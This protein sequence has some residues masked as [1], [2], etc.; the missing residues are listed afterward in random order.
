M[1]DFEVAVRA[2][3]HS[4]FA[5]GAGRRQRL[6]RGLRG[7]LLERTVADGRLRDGLFR[8]VDVLPQ[9]NGA[10]EVAEHLHAYLAAVPR[11]G[12][13]G[14]LF[15]LAA[16]P[17]LA[18]MVRGMVH[19]LARDFM[20][21]ES[22]HGL[23]RILAEL[24]RVPAAA[25]VDAVG[26]AVL[27]EA[28]ADAYLARNLKLLGWLAGRGRPNISIKLTGLSPRFDPLD[29]TGTRARVEA[30]LAPLLDAAV[31]TRATVTVDMEQRDL[32]GQILDLF[33]AMAADFPGDWQPA[34]AMQA[35]LPEAPDDLAR[36]VA[37][38]ERQGRRLGV[39]LVK[40]AY[41]DQEQAWAAQ[42]G[43]PVP[44]LGDKA[45]TDSQYESL[46]AWLF[47]RSE[48]L[49]PAVA[50]HNLRSQSV[51]LAHA[52]RR[53][54]PMDG[55][56]WEA[57]MLYGMAEPLRDALAAAGVPLR[58]YV[59]T[60]ELES[61]I[62]YLIRRLL[63]N[64]ASTSILQQTQVE[65]LDEA[66]LLAAPTPVAAPSP[67]TR[68]NLANVPLLDFSVEG[69]RGR[70][71]AAL[72]SLRAELPRR[73]ARDGD[74][75]F[76]ARNPARPAEELGAVDLVDAAAVDAAVHR[77]RLAFAGWSATPATERCAKLRRAADLIVE[78]RREL[79]ALEVLEVAKPWREADADVAEAADFLRY[80]AGQ[81]E[82]LAGWRATIDF[83]GEA[84]RCAYAPRGVAVVIAPWNFPLA[85][86]AGM[87]GAALAAGNCAIMKPA[88]SALLVAHELRD[89]LLAA[90]VPAD[91]A[92]LLPGD[93]GVGAALVGHADIDVIAFT[94]SRQV[95]LHILQAAYTPAPGQRHVKQVVCEMGGKNAIVVDADADLDEAV[96]GILV[97]AFGYSGQKCSACSRIIAVDAVHDRLLARLAAA[98][99]ALA[100]GPP[101]NPACDHGPLI[102]EAARDKALAYIEIGRREGRLVW[103]GRVPEDGG[104]YAPPAIFAGIEPHHRLARD[105]VF[106]PVLA[107]L[108]AGNFREALAMAGD[109]DYA[110]TGGVYSRLPP[111]LML[112]AESFRVGNLYLNRRITGAR[113]GVQPFGGIA[114]SGT[115]V[116]AGGPDYLKQFLWT[117]SVSENTMRHGMLPA[118]TNL[119]GWR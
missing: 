88:L 98:A 87:T 2:I 92:Q 78:R 114:L 38:A 110:L 36:V 85:I 84:N 67:D 30:R 11:S 111:H 50:S 76:V 48:V 63:E 105:E 95:G 70:F 112:A 19:R 39:R 56:R 21:E 4:L 66:A 12:W 77:A 6:F 72:A 91:A 86:L 65:R 33:L 20:A 3:G 80:Y 27:S 90:G 60:G 58:I 25:T 100:W 29:A 59:P 22:E 99:D 118:A 24:A 97:S 103:L 37:C 1:D 96:A 43:W 44:T 117:R 16:R 51:A 69:E 113:V 40:G 73:M 68:G 49:H 42:R 31:R 109:S 61:G 75:C 41:W 17:G 45:A 82:D 107:V 71:A 26:E 64:T 52:R 93:A 9:L 7:A 53:G 102:T 108:L 83:P 18:W 101:E 115:G 94:G 28:E 119:P 81:M 32:K 55:S 57:Q 47:E 34:V 116:Q 89:I 74:A 14:L 62:A 5:A 10:A 79:A 13:E 8:L 106:G 104:W 35:Y 54:L 15:R 23:A 46:T